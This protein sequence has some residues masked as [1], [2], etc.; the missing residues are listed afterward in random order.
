VPDPSRNGAVTRPFGALARD[1]RDAGRRRSR[2][3]RFTLAAVLILS[4]GIGAVTAAFS[5]V[6]AALV[7]GH[8]VAAPERVVDI[9]HVGSNPGGIDG[10]SYPVY[11]DIAARSDV[12]SATTAAL[13]PRGV[14]YLDGGTLRPAV[15]EHTTATYLAVLGQ[16]PAIGRWFDAAEDTPGA[17]T[18]AVVG[19][20]AWRRK[21]G[22]DPA[23]VGRVVRIDGVPVTVVGV[24]PAGHRG[25]I[26]TGIVTDF[27][28]PI[29]TLSVFAAPPRMLERRPDEAAFLVKARLR[30]GVSVVQARAALDVLGTR[31]ASE[32]PAE[33][34]GKGFTVLPSNDVRIHPQMDG[35]VTG[36]ATV[37]LAVV[38]LVL[39]IACSNLATLLLVRGAARTKEMSVRLALGATRAQ[40]VRQLLTESVMLS[41][42]GGA[43]GC[44]LA[45]WAVRALSAVD[46]PVVL[47]LALDARVLVFALAMSLLTGVAFGLAPARETS[48]IDLVPTLRG[49]RE[50]GAGRARWLTVKHAF[51][52]LQVAASAAL[53][54]G[55]SL[56]L[57][58]LAASQ[59]QRV[60]FA[61]DGVAMAETDPRYAGYTSQAAD[62]LLAD[63]QRRVGALP[64]VEASAQ[65]RG[66]PMQ[67]TGLAIVVEGEAPTSARPAPRRLA[68]A[69]WAG[70]AY[71]DVLRIPILFGRALDARDRRETRRVAVISETMARQ[72]FGASDV[73]T[74]VGR[75]FR[76]ERD[77]AAD[78]WMEV[79]GV[80]RDTG[81]AD[82]PGDLV[83]PEPQVFFRPF[84][85]WDVAPTT[86]IARTALD[87]STLAGAM[88]R[89]VRAVDPALPVV[90]ARTM[91][92]HLDASLAGPRAVVTFLA[93]LGLLGLALA[94]IG[95]YAVVAF[96]VARRSR[97]IGI[98][99]A[100]GARPGQVVSAVAGDVAVLLG[101]GT[102]IGLLVTLLATQALRAA[103]IPAPG[104]SLYRPTADPLALAGIAAFMLAVGLA[105]AAV[106]ARRATRVD[107]L[108]ALRH[109]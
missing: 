22:A 56:V 103:T 62:A 57:Q 29:A 42:A 43:G 17:A 75:R 106:P 80:A 10:N 84:A 1:L 83:D 96:A 64:G 11:L 16:Q 49:E 85:Q 79:V 73:A 46:L 12:F 5:L 59:A 52:I 38:G 74:A 48:R 9:Y 47:D 39:A 104:L 100:L 53:L 25:T 70:P 92:Q 72:Y 60:G 101:V 63:I 13:V 98:R 54:G 20:D 105:A 88:Q 41:V 33:D 30:D 8:A 31:L 32:Y 66:L 65:T 45:W 28:L 40:I 81:T 76:L 78:G 3:W 34:P 27:W 55:T 2:E 69:I 90:A 51:V 44:L 107:P 108:T 99:T 50:P 67:V 102:G 26:N 95:L 91:A 89:E 19:H 4:L 35:V 24:G 94:G 61:V 15:V 21:F 37:L 82:R 7:R 36:A 71:F 6:N 97:E 86:V 87:A 23:V 68:G 77:I 58:L 93:G 14:T 18:V 109:D